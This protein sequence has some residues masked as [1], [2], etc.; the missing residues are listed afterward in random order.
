MRIR[1]FIAFPL[2]LIL[3]LITQMSFAKQIELSGFTMGTYY[4][5]KYIDNDSVLSAKEIQR[6]I[7]KKLELVNDQMSTWRPESELSRFNAG[8]DVNRPF[9]ISDDLAFVIR[10]A[11]EINKI[12]QGGLDITIGPLVNLWGFGPEK[13][14]ERAPSQDEITARLLTTGMD[15]LVLED[16][17]L[18][19]QV[20]GLYLDL[21]A[22]A[23]G[24]G[25]DVISDYLQSQSFDN[26]MVDIG[27]EIRAHGKNQDNQ[28]WRIAIEK[29]GQDLNRQVYEIVQLDNQAIATSGSYRNY[30]NDK[31]KRYSHTIDPKTGYPIK[32]NIISISV[33][34]DSCM[35]A[36]G[37]ATGLYV[38]GSQNSIGLA[39]RLNIPVMVIVDN[40]GKLESHYSDA[41]KTLLERQKP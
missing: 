5:I 7:D 32:H 11:V 12:T 33:V 41:F 10:S 20:A 31:D 34:H 38:L 17:H 27:G 30:F 1:R 6:E 36:D 29:P 15:K 21:S 22:I 25:V 19:K 13:K 35:Y 14:T 23:K 3:L 26:Y 24:Y 4:S 39:N 16:R 28:A 8:S 2:T 37:L 9:L 40:D 18:S